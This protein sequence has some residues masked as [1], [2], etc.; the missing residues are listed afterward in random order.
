MTQLYIVKQI[1]ITT[2]HLYVLNYGK[3]ITYGFFYEH[4]IYGCELNQAQAIRFDKN[5]ITL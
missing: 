1:N 3:N 2:I 5:P 4:G